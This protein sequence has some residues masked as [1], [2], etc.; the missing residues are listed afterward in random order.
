MDAEAQGSSPVTHSLINAVLVAEAGSWTSAKN[1]SIETILS[2]ST[3][4]ANNLPL[5]IQVRSTRAHLAP[6]YL[7][8]EERSGSFLLGTIV[9]VPSTC[10]TL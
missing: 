4:V 5:L 1:N 6:W 9:D 3:G 8:P 7:N 10:P 2:L